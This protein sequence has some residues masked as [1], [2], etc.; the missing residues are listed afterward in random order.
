MILEKK[1]HFPLPWFV[2]IT[3]INWVATAVNI[4]ARFMG[5]ELMSISKYIFR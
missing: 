4:Y 3:N 2:L 5:E 1:M